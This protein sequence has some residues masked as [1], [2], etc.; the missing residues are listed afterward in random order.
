MLQSEVYQP[1]SVGDIFC[2]Q[3]EKFLV[4]RELLDRERVRCLLSMDGAT[5]EHIIV[6]TQ[7]LW[8]RQRAFWG[9]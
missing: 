3:D 5:G 9:K 4:V 6:Y 8:G 2:Y 7:D 1:I